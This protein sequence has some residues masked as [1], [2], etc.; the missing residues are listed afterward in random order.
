MPKITIDLGTVVVY[1]DTK[2]R[3]KGFAHTVEVKA[4]VTVDTDDLHYYVTRAA[5]NKSRRAMLAYG[6]ITIKTEDVPN[7]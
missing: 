1:P 5:N 3:E 2:V 7:V 4:T 6:A